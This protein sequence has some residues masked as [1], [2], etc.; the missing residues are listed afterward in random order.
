MTAN[1]QKIKILMPTLHYYPVIGGFEIFSRNIARI[2]S[3]ENEFYVVCGKVAGEPSKTSKGNLKIIRTGFWRLRNLSR[4]SALYILTTFI[5]V[6]YRSLFLVW[7]KKIDLLHCQGFISGFVGLS[8]KIFFRVPY[9][10]TIQS[11]D[12]AIYH[13]K[14]SRGWMVRVKL[15]LEKI[16]FSGA[17]ARHAVSND[18]V[19]YYAK[20]GLKDGLMVPNGVDRDMFKPAIDRMSLRKKLGFMT[21]NLII[22]VS[23]LEHKN[24]THDLIGAARLLKKNLADFKL[25]IIGRGTEEK[26]LKKMAADFGL[27]QNVVFLGDIRHSDLPNYL[28]ASD[29]FVRP[30]LAEGFGIAFI[31]AMAAG[32]AVVGTTVGGIADFLFHER[33]G[34]VAKAGD[35]QSVKEQIFRLVSD[36]QLKDRVEQEAAKMVA[37]KYDWDAI[38][39]KIS[40]IYMSAIRKKRVLVVSGIFPPDIGGP[41]TFLVNL[42]ED[43]VSKGL[44]ICVLTFGKKEPA[45]KYR[46]FVKKVSRSWIQPVRTMMFFFKAI[47]CAPAHD[48]FYILDV[49]SSG[50]AGF[51]AAKITRKKTIIRFVGDSAWE[52]AVSRGMTKCDLMDFQKEKSPWRVNIRKKLRGTMLRRSDAVVVASEY[53][54]KI[55]LAIGTDERRILII[56][57][58]VD[59]LEVEFNRLPAKSESKNKLGLS[60]AVILSAA[61]LAPWKGMDVLI[62]AFSAVANENAEA[63]LVI[64]GEGA[65][66]GN[67]EKLIKDLGLSKRAVLIG[68][69]SRDKMFE[70]LNAA[71]IFALN[72]NYEGMSHTILEAMRLG[73]PIV[74]TNAGGNPETIENGVSGILVDYNDEKSMADAINK[75]FKDKILAF[76]LGQS[77]KNKVKSFDW[78][79]VIEKTVQLIRKI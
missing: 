64:L 2:I 74:T 59:F 43:L 1:K 50:M 72:T 29:V 62:R 35:A 71:D 65:Q 47:I 39:K 28:A 52:Y 12:Y 63:K 37:E 9:V 7:L 68:K 24:G 27:E 23:R 56:N 36:R 53:L 60:G 51:A 20:L 19:A 79:T 78:P 54:K 66:Y 55:V 38:A 42:A 5:C 10:I 61:R 77:A 17:A 22:C 18:L 48:I 40:E 75:L 76:A 57:S 44:K 30:A 41:A 45:K 25:I 21:D 4:S 11:A 13:P 34:L 15:Y 69:V 67:L 32:V 31:E 6:L 8:V 46:F 16:V 58:S 33:T 14:F 49:Y 73:L 70:Y 26:K 3:R